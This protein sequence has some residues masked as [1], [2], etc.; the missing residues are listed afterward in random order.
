ML[1]FLLPGVLGAPTMAKASIF[2][3]IL[4]SEVSASTEGLDSTP[5]DNSQ[6]MGLLEAIFSPLLA[7]ADTDSKDSKN[8][9][10]GEVKVD[11]TVQIAD[12]A[13]V[14]TTGPLGVS[15]GT[16]TTDTNFADF[17]DEIS[18][19]VVHKG[20]TLAKIAD[21][22]DVTTDTILSA[23]D[24]KKGDK[25]KEGDVLLIPPFSG[26]E[27]T[28]TKGQ[29]LQSIAKL[30]NAD[31][32][33]ISTANH[34]EGTKIVVGDKLVIPG[35]ELQTPK[36]TTPPKKNTLPSNIAVNSNTPS[37]GYFI[38]PVPCRLTQGKHDR[39]A[40]DLGCPTGTPILASA[41][42]RVMFARTGWNG[43]FGN[44]V[45]I[46]HPNGTQTFYAHQSKI[47]VSQGEQV[48][49]GQVIGYVGSTGRSTGPHLH[50][51]VRGA[52][53]PGFDNSWATR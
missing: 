44:L 16:E 21:M 37:N 6:K 47:A 36:T 1:F 31:I 18:I 9:K 53:N 3:S 15:D 8:P 17:Q 30:Y 38:K 35:G 27:H 5:S 50:F 10:E 22:F 2:S 34:L 49:Q 40:V 48:T 29:T 45:I 51:E 23:N 14:P 7:L 43:A 28:V 42:G 33:E 32:D 4:G 13:L 46:S 52:K 25:P 24:M 26:V 12:N 20:D 39:Y 11:A 19:Y 41:S